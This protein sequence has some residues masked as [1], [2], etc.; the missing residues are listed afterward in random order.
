MICASCDSVCDRKSKKRVYCDPCGK[1]RSAQSTRDAKIKAREKDRVNRAKAPIYIRCTTC[2]AKVPKR[3]S[4]Q[5]FCAEC[6]LK[7]DADSM[8]RRNA[9]Y[10]Q[11]PD[12]K[13]DNARRQRERRERV[14][15]Y[16]IGARMSA[17]IY[18][19]LST[20]KAGRKWESIVGYTLE[21][22]ADHLERQFLKGMSWTNYGEWHIDH[23]RPIASFG[24]TSDQDQ[25]FRDCWALSNLRPLW[26]L[27]NISKNARRDFL[28]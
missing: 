14:P 6:R 4:Q 10:R 19:A 1:R 26:A 15:K 12:A 24:Y 27:A 8:R 2:E 23:I 7:S 16:A 18:D 28:I 21:Q 13:E 20:R 11:R 5:K 22:L 9:R 3:T 25:E 17:A